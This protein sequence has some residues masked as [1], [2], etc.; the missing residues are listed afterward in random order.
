[1]IK[2]VWGRGVMAAAEALRAFILTDVWVRVPPP[3]P[4]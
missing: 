3:L 2:P 1:M 4:F